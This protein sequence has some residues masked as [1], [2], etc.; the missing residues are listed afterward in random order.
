MIYLADIDGST[1][2]ITQQESAASEFKSDHEEV[3][4]KM[5]AS[6]KNIATENPIK[7]MIIS[8]PYTDFAV[9]HV[10]KKYHELSQ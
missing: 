8:S 4:T 6:G 2:K 3:D 1:I 5:F 10:F 9:M 7:R